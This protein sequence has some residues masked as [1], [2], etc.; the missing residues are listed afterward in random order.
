[1]SQF[2]FLDLSKPI[3]SQLKELPKLI[4]MFNAGEPF[5]F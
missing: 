1:M 4:P 3:L 2:P 5:W